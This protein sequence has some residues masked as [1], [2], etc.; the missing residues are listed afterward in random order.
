MTS[1][2]VPS[3]RRLPVLGHMHLFRPGR[4]VQGLMAFAR[5]FDGI[6]HIQLGRS[7]GLVV[8]TAALAAELADES[9]FRKV[10]SKPLWEVRAVVGD[11]LFTARSDEP[12]WAIAHRVLMPAFSQRAMRGYF[13]MMLQVADQLAAKW[14]SL[15]GVDIPVAAD[16]TRLTMDT[17]SLAGFG[18]P[19]N[20]F[21]NPVQHPFL[22]A[23]EAALRETMDR[24]TQVELVR[25]LYR[26]RARAFAANLATMNA[27]VDE[28]V[29]ERRATP[30]ESGDLLNLMLTARDPETGCAARRPQYPVPGADLPD[31]GA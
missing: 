6:F 19:F 3:P 29:R 23:M 25:P 22:T 27:L 21:A 10:L 13:P 1:H 20:S 7:G 11:G 2:P 26:R 28:V 31:R 16:M 30:V 18:R 9:R 15:P 12:N 24:L 17:I 5:Q 14:E 4:F 8:T